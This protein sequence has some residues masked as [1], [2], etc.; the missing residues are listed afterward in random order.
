MGRMMDSEPTVFVVD[1]D[2]ASRNAV[3]DLV[4]TMNLRCE[5]FA[6]GQDFLEACREPRRGCLVVGLRVLGASGLEI[7]QRLLRADDPL[8]VIFLTADA[9]V[10]IAVEAMRRGAVH[11]LEKPY[12][13]HEL[14]QAIQEAI[15][16]DRRRHERRRHRRR[17][18]RRLA[19]LTP[20][21]RHVLQLLR[22]GKPSKQIA[23]ELKLGL[24]MVEV[25]R[26]KLAKK[27]GDCAARGLPGNGTT[28]TR[29]R[30][31]D[32]EPDALGWLNG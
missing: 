24:R 15:E 1:S 28:A 11:F 13:T 27:L 29:P 9:D 5:V 25:H 20:K 8:P 32:Q 7:Q 23:S 18:R 26:A 4:G 17:M 30:P 10:S 19:A 14:W 12:R 6:S 31:Q 3:R 22:Q 2:T 21:E 16:L